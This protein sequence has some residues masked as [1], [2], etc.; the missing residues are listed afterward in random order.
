VIRA[1]VQIRCTGKGGRGAKKGKRRECMGNE[2]ADTK[3]AVVPVVIPGA[4]KKKKIKG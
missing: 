2:E 4:A 3:V 1:H